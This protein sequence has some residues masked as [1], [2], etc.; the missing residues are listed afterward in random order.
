MFVADPVAI[1]TNATSP[2]VARRCICFGS[3]AVSFWGRLV[4]LRPRLTRGK[5]KSLKVRSKA[6]EAYTSRV[7]DKAS[8]LS[9]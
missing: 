1:T 5:P 7:E 3:P 8:R 4:D 9:K 2:F 6:V